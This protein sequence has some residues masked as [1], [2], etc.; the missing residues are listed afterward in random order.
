VKETRTMQN[1]DTLIISNVSDDPFAI[2]LAHMCGQVGEIADLISLKVYANTEFCPRYISDEGDLERVGRSLEGKTV[3]ICSAATSDT[4]G[5][6]AMRTMMLAR[7]AKD[8]GASKVI[9]VEPDLF[10]SAQD[11]GPHRAEGEDNR[12]LEDL[13]KFDG[14]PFTASLYA[15]LLKLSGVDAVITVHNHS[16]KVQRLFSKAFGGGFYNLIPDAVYADYLKYSDMVVT[17]KDGEN[18]VLCAPDMGALPFVG[19]VRDSLHLP[20]AACIMME[21]SRTGERQVR[22]A[23]SAQSD[24]RLDQIE[25]KDVIILDD[26][27]RTGST[28]VECCRLLREGNPRKIV[29]GVTHFYS[30]PEGRENLN[31]P[32]L[33]EI[34]SLNTI[35]SILNRDS[36]GRLRKKM[37]VL[38]IEKWIARFLLGHLGKD[39][40]KFDRDF[41]SVDMSTKNPRWKPTLRLDR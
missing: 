3:V 9:L 16:A 20:G 34:L 25:G 14:Q 39:T 15:D 19:Q 1:G 40:S 32:A 4:R 18:L 22:M 2:D 28:V 41:Y 30:S 5:S 13:K 12:P 10:F 38:K 8:N 11:R 37:V 29:F 6:L 23:V 27:V 35:P 24:L 17:G 36:Q 7:G 31:S 26:M 33:D 21:K